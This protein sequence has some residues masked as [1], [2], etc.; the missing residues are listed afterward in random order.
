MLRQK[1]VTSV[2]IQGL[3][4]RAGEREAVLAGLALALLGP[5][6]LAGMVAGVA[7]TNHAV[8]EAQEAA[9]RAGED[10][11]ACRSAMKERW[12]PDSKLT[13]LP[14]VGPGESVFF[15]RHVRVQR[16]RP[17]VRDGHVE[18]GLQRGPVPPHHQV[19]VDTAAQ[20]NHAAAAQ[21][22]RPIQA[23]DGGANGQGVFP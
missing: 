1:R 9:A 11:A 23:R 18:V 19:T 20:H 4:G 5:V 17:V 12:W 2:A 13:Y 7:A 10:V 15:L 21:H 8:G 16:K 22:Q 14:A 6:F 3:S